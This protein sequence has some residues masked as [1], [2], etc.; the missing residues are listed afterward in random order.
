MKVKIS[1]EYGEHYLRNA[2]YTL[3][4]HDTEGIVRD[5]DKVVELY[6]LRHDEEVRDLERRRIER[7]AADAVPVAEAT[8]DDG[9]HARV[10]EYDGAY[11]CLDCGGLWGAVSGRPPVP[12]LCVKQYLEAL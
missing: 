1:V 2:E 7:D 12:K 10:F 9:P 4:S 6:R 3:D 11:R 8:R 5:L